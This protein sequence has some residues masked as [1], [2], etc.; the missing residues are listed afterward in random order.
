[1]SRAMNPSEIA[2]GQ[3]AAGR[4]LPPSRLD[5][6]LLIC[7]IR[8]LGPSRPVRFQ[9]P[10]R[11]LSDTPSQRG[12]SAGAFALPV[13]LLR[14]LSLLLILSLA[15]LA[16]GCGSKET[17]VETG[18]RDQ[19][20][21]K[22]NA[23]EP[24][25]LDPHTMVSVEEDNIMQALFEPLVWRHPDT[26]VPVP[27]AAERW[28]VSADGRAYTFHLRK[29][30]RWSNGDPVTA[31]DFA[32][33]YQRCLTPELAAEFAFYL[34]PIRGAEAFNTG[35]SKD[36]STVGV[37]AVD[38]HTLKLTLAEPTPYFLSLLSIATYM[39]VQRATV[40]KA[41]GGSRKGTSWTRPGNHVGNGPFTLSEW[42]PS[43]RI[44][45][46]RNTN[47]WDAAN[48]RL[49]EVRFYPIENSD[50]EERAFRAGQLHLTAALPTSK[51]AAYKKDEPQFLRTVPYLRAQYIGCN[52]TNGVLANRLVRRALGLALDREGIVNTVTRGGETPAWSF[53]APKMAGYESRARLPFDPAAAKKAL[54]AAGFPDGKGFPKLDM[55]FDNAEI[56]KITGEAIQQMWRATLGI[57]V[58]LQNMEKK[59]YLDRTNQ[60]DYQLYLG[61]WTP[62]YPDPMGF[63]EMWGSSST[64]NYAGFRN[65][66][67]DDFLARSGRELDVAKRMELIRQAEDVL[68]EEAPVLPIYHHARVYLSRPSVKG[69]HSNPLDTHAYTRVFLQAGGK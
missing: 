15:L 61:G 31:H 69:W 65:S 12:G 1:M 58:G 3:A 11:H 52:V 23:T 37:E 67:Y 9:L 54:A 25:D 20:L 53:V 8:R 45:L 16:T 5:V 30:A 26:M 22:G 27:G 43:K 4:R 18:D 17:A 29:N 66:A 39:P 59:V 33:S 48:V 49:A 47:Y 63:L 62:D 14:S 2:G 60:K 32:Y 35:K 6:S 55:I 64:A 42:S 51:I 19:I 21:H 10:A 44:T 56:T 40:E 36:F 50:T 28:D 7:P 57:E 46:R 34:Y 41:G 68:T 38:D 13:L 24:R